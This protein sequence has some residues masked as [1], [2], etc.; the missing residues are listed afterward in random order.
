MSQSQRDTLEIL[1]NSIIAVLITVCGVFL[2]KILDKVEVSYERLIRVEEAVEQLKRERDR[3]SV[4][5]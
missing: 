5:K 4:S 3:M 1:K 2:Y